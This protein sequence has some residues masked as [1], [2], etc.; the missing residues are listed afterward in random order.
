M[1]VLFL[2]SLGVSMVRIGRHLL[3]EK[4]FPPSLY[5]G[6]DQTSRGATSSMELNTSLSHGSSTPHSKSLHLTNSSKVTTSKNGSLVYSAIVNTSRIKQPDPTTWAL[7]TPQGLMGGYRNQV[8]RLFGMVIG[9]TQAKVKQILLPSMLWSTMN[10]QNQQRAVPMEDLFDI[11][12]WNSFQSKLPKFVR[13]IHAGDC[14]YPNVETMLRENTELVEKIRSRPDAPLLEKVLEKPR[15]L[16]PIA[17]ISLAYT[18][19][20]FIINPRRFDLSATIN[21]CTHPVAYGAGGGR[22]RLWVNYMEYSRKREKNGGLVQADPLEKSFLQAL[23]PHSKWRSLAQQCVINATK[24]SS[25]SVVDYIALHPRIEAEMMN[26]ACGSYMN[27]NLTKILDDTQQLIERNHDLAN[28]AGIFVALSRA[29]ASV[30]E[31]AAYRRFRD[32]IDENTHTLNM[33]LGNESFAAHGLPLTQ[34]QGHIPVFECGDKLLERYYDS[35]P[36]PIVDYGSLLPSVINFDVAVEAKAFIGMRYSSWSNSVWTTRYYQGRGDT[37]FE[38][39]R[40]RGIQQIENGGLPP[41]HQNCN[42]IKDPGR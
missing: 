40:E 41:P 21:N 2:L 38:Y 13:N 12:H 18:T 42:G 37:N 24:Q 15:F 33:I 9:A 22:G 5:Q 16:K 14:W 6:Y 30:T 27:K 20:E 26:H 29:G 34:G 3:N 10:R 31:G 1:E 39:T 11:D 7:V 19:G 35:Q 25:N 4:T 28:I 8:I 17:N 32:Y 36:Q 23:R